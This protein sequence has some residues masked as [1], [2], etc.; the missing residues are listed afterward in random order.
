MIGATDHEHE[1]ERL[2][3]LDPAEREV[4]GSRRGEEEV[5]VD[6]RRHR[7]EEDVLDGGGADQ[8]ADGRAGDRRCGRS[9]ASPPCRP[10]RAGWR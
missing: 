9:P 1:G 8:A 2:V 3:V 10:M 5:A 4:E 7:G 6:Q